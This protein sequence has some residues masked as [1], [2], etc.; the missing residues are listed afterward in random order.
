MDEKTLAALK[1]ELPEI[2]FRENVPWHDVTSLKAGGNIR[3]LAEPMDDIALAKLLKFCLE[4]QVPY[5]MVG[6]GTNL[7]GADNYP[8]LLV[9]RLIHGNFIRICFA[10]GRIIAGA[11]VRLKD[12]A[13]I[14]AEHGYGGLAP[15]VGIPGRLGGL[16]RMNAGANGAN[17]SDY[18]H[19]VCGFDADGQSWAMMKNEIHWGY[20]FSSIPSDAVI[21]AAIF[22]L[23]PASADEEQL[24]KDELSKRSRKEPH[25]CTAG[26]TF[27]NVSDAD[28]AGK[29]IDDAGLKNLSVGD[30]VVSD[31]HANFIIN[32][33]HAG[34]SDVAELISRIQAEVADRFGFYLHPEVAFADPRTPEKFI[35]PPRIAVLKGGA[36]SEREV[37]LI[38]GAAVAR[39]LRRSGYVVDELDI[40]DLEILP[41]MLEADLVFPVLHGGWGEGGG[42]Q[43]L[44]EKAGVRFVGSGSKVCKLIMDKIT[45]KEL[46][47]KLNLPTPAWGVI[48]TANPKLP[49]NLSFPVVVK[50]PNEGS[51]VGIEIV[52]TADQWEAA[53]KRAFKFDSRL[54]VEEF[55]TGIEGTVSIIDGKAYPV[56]EIHPPENKIYDYDA[57]YLHQSG[58]TLYL[59]PPVNIPED[60][61][62]QAQEA[63]L[64]F[65][66]G[67]GASGLLRVDI[68][69][70]TDGRVVLLEG[71]NMPG[72]TDSS[73]VPKAAKSVGIAFERL[74]AMLV[75]KA[76]QE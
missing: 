74:C 73:L 21:T 38:S 16:L 43:E 1:I 25:G 34:E 47:E 46:M 44:M 14:C 39:A 49:E 55:V 45:S 64:K 4:H 10:P 61:Q 26:C 27:R 58:E 54:L 71:N 42:I 2:V 19:E 37:S 9:I 22:H 36:S 30:A 72:F 12:F 13:K 66:E 75:R 52:K 41:E 32:K 51:T 62:K 56:I 53:L 60:L 68:F 57:K 17:I 76:L 23:P 70:T 3:I 33:G 15:L 50:P 7:I 24:I 40:R 67:S 29:I 18:L 48:T 69:A 8:E 6:N 11:G 5:L 20:R 31:V 65:Y 59:C 28:P 63:S 35:K